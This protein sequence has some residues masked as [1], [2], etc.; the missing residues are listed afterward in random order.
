MQYM[1]MGATK[2]GVPTNQLTQ[3]LRMTWL[4]EDRKRLDGFRVGDPR[5]LAEVY[6]HYSPQISRTIA[7]G[8]NVRTEDGMTRFQGLGSA[9][10]LA[11]VV[12]E[13]F[14]RAFRQ[15]ARDSYDGLRPFRAYLM[16]IARNLVLDLLRRGGKETAL[17]L[18]L[19]NDSGKE[20]D[21]VATT[22]SPEEAAFRN[23]LRKVYES[24]LSIQSAEDR[25]VFVERFVEGRSRQKVSKRTG[26]SIMQIRTREDRIRLQLMTRLA[27]CDL[28]PSR[29][30]LLLLLLAIG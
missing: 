12:Q 17:F 6:K 19:A 3:A 13:T 28:G 15:K 5:V 11:D 27:A 10:D 29:W 21:V 7:L 16:A 23:E 24:F 25:A 4:L 22:E 9:F 20:R 2:L 18:P 26:L 8:F 30:A 1:A 14:V